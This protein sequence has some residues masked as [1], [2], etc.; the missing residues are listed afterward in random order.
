MTIDITPALG[1]EGFMEVPELEYL[2]CAARKSKRIL[3]VGSWKGRSAIVMAYNTKGLVHCVDTWSGHL[4]ASDHFSADCFKD[5][6]KNTNCFANILPIPLE[7][8][9]CAS[10]FSQFGYRFDMIFIDGRH[11]YDGV[12]RDIKAWKPLLS[13]NGILCGHDYG[14]PD[15][16]D[17]KNVV[18]ELVSNFRVVRNTNIWTTEVE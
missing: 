15:W 11:D 14:H 9:H 3:E 8:V 17:V 2:A 5:F 18:D 7:S 1:I 12:V 16:P 10:I 13:E 6:L 4:D